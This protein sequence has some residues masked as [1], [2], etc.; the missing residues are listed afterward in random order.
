[1]F[2]H[3]KNYL[4][5]RRVTAGGEHFIPGKPPTTSHL[6]SWG[7][8]G[9]HICTHTVVIHT[10]IIVPTSYFLRRNSMNMK[11]AAENLIAQINSQSKLATL[12]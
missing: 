9:S 3:K 5:N 11:V 4:Q 7:R 8:T 12:L 6:L 10:I 2:I 1:M